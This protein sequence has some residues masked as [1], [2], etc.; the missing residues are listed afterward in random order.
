MA[1][2]SLPPFVRRFLVRRRLRRLCRLWLVCLLLILAGETSV[3]PALDC[4]AHRDRNGNRVLGVLDCRTPCSQV[5]GL[6]NRLWAWWRGS[7]R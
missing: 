4:R 3:V 7:C 2:L 5:D 1:A 6:V